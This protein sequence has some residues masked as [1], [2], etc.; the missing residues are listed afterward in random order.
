LPTTI[1]YVAS[2]GIVLC[3]GIDVG[4]LEHELAQ[5]MRLAQIGHGFEFDVKAACTKSGDDLHFSCYV[6]GRSGGT[7]V[8]TWTVGVACR[9]AREVTGPRCLSDNGYALQ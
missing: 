5:V 6:T 8:T 7:L 2:R 9:P 3:A 4:R 1:A